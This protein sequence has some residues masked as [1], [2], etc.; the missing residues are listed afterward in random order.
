MYVHVVAWLYAH[1]LKDR[2]NAQ[3]FVATFDPTHEV[4]PVRLYLNMR[5]SYYMVPVNLFV[6]TVQK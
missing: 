6:D 2:D 1:L 4:K 5:S 3:T